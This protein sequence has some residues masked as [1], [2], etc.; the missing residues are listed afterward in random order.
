[1]AEKQYKQLLFEFKLLEEIKSLPSVIK[2]LEKTDLTLKEQLNIFFSVKNSLKTKIFS[3]RFDQIV[4]KNVDFK[5]FIDA[6]KNLRDCKFKHFK[7]VNLTNA[8][9]ERSFSEQKQFISSQGN[10]LTV[11]KLFQRLIAK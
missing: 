8:N 1:M 11:K 5:F 2:N 7:Y 3:D 10:N 4:D 6:S 9:I